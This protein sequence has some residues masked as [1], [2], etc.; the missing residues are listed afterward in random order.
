MTRNEKFGTTKGNKIRSRSSH[1]ISMERALNKS[2]KEREGEIEGK[3][4]KGSREKMR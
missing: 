3:K 1:V 4:E 2:L